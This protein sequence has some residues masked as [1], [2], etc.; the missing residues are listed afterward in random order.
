MTH[1]S[2]LVNLSLA[3]VGGSVGAG[4]GNAQKSSAVAGLSAATSPIV[5]LASNSNF[6]IPVSAP[7]TAVMELALA[8]RVD[9]VALDKTTHQP[10]AGEWSAEFGTITESGT[11]ITPA[12]FFAEGADYLMFVS[13]TGEVS[14]FLIKLSGQLSQ[15]PDPSAPLITVDNP[16]PGPLGLAVKEPASLE[17]DS[18]TITTVEVPFV[19]DIRLAID[20]SGIEVKAPVGLDGTVQFDLNS[21]EPLS[22]VQLV[23]GQLGYL[24]DPDDQPVSLAVKGLNSA[25]LAGTRCKPLFPDKAPTGSCPDG[26]KRTVAGPLRGKSGGFTVVNGGTV[27]VSG[28]ISGEINRI[29]GVNVTVGTTANVTY[30]RSHRHEWQNQDRYECRNGVWTYVGTIHCTRICGRVYDFSPRW[31][32][33]IFGFTSAGPEYVTCPAFDC[34]GL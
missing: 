8:Q 32:A 31:A 26:S 13:D 24:F 14:T 27:T 12:N 10:V 19:Y 15:S 18:T 11:Y 2:L 22:T 30:N 16:T 6:S 3:L 1:K 5:A 7:C 34:M 28:N 29:F 4:F 21:A 9:L 33:Y 23:D 25:P 20:G 17:Q